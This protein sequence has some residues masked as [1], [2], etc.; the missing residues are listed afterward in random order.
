M[1]K[2]ID[3]EAMEELYTQE[4]FDRHNS[5]YHEEALKT[6]L[7]F[8]N[9]AL[10][11]SLSSTYYTNPN[12]ITRVFLICTIRTLLLVVNLFINLSKDP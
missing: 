10:T 2:F 12:V 4:Q 1:N 9:H 8:W 7:N 6:L 11:G 5:S 3:N